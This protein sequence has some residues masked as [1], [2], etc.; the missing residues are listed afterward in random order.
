M[1]K[2]TL[3]LLFIT[4][5]TYSQTTVEEYNYVTKGYAETI[6]KGL[7]LKKGYSLNEVY[8]YTDTNYDFLFKSL[9]NDKTKK[10]SCIMVIANSRVWGNKYYLCMPIGNGDLE[11]KYKE[12]LSLWDAPILSAYSLA[13]SQIL[14]YSL[15]SVE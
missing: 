10:T 8:H 2:I 13:L 14:T 5:L 9:T 4:S 7:D 12:Q 6:A 15:A 3:F 11:K 1:K